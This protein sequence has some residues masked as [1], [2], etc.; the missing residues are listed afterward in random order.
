MF[1]TI[2]VAGNVGKDPESRYTPAGKMVTSFSLATNR[3]WTKED[4]TQVK[5]TAWFR[6]TVWGKQAETVSTYVHKGSKVLVE[7]RLNVDPATGGPKVFS[8][9][10][11][12]SGASFDVTAET[13]RFLD[14]KGSAPEAE[15]EPVSSEEIAF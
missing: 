15:A 4:G 6:V 12:T 8:R 5:E 10:N 14:S 2:I 3:G 7:G 1:H 11:G 9:D 13:V